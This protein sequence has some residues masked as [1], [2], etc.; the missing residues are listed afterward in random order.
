MTTFY[1]YMYLT[2]HTHVTMIILE[3]SLSQYLYHWSEL[4]VLHV[5]FRFFCTWLLEKM[6]SHSKNHTSFQCC[7]ICK[8]QAQS[9]P[10]HWDELPCKAFPILASCLVYV[11]RLI[12]CK[13]EPLWGTY[14]PHSHHIHLV[15]N[16]QGPEAYFL[17]SASKPARMNDE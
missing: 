7:A 2:P 15:L 1:L 16:Q 3:A 10:S 14:T 4:K 13:I 6:M 9:M 17:L 5:D 11:E 8:F 12:G